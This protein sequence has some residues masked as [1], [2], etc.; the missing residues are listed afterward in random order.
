M[1][2]LKFDEVRRIT[3]A[4]L[5]SNYPGALI[6][7]FVDG[8]DPK[9]VWHVWQKHMLTIFEALNWQNEKLFYRSYTGGISL[10][11]SA[12][13]DALYTACDAAELGWEFCVAELEQKPVLNKQEKIQNLQTTLKQEI[14]PY[15]LKLIASAEQNNVS[16]LVDD[17]YFSL[18]TGV[19][20][21]VWEIDKLP[22]IKGI[23]WSKYHKIPSALITGTNGKSTSVRLASTIA[24]ADNYSAGVTSTDFIRVGDNIIDKGDY[25]GPGGARILLRHPETEIAF[26]EVARGGLLRRGVPINNNQAALI[27]NIA[28]D[29]LGQYGI[30][31]VPELAEAKFIVD[32]GLAHDGVLV[33]N[34]DDKELEKMSKK[35]AH[36]ICWFST[37]KNNHLI[38][39][40]IQ[41]GEPVVYCDSGNVYF[42]DANRSNN[43]N[44]AVKDIVMTFNGTATY[45]IYNA[46]GVIGLCKVLKLSDQAIL[47]GLASFGSNAQDNPGRGNRYEHHGAEV[48]IDF[49]HN[50]HSMNAVINMVKNIDANRKIVMFSQA[51]DRS[52]EEI[53]S[54]ADEILKLNPQLVIVAEIKNYLRGRAVG[55]IPNLIKKHLLK[56]QMSDNQIKTFNS[57]VEGAQYAIDNLQ[58]G[59][60]ALLF[61]LDQREGVHQ[62]LVG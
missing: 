7:A 54:L 10:S 32:K 25:S 44:V 41:Q 6:D 58:Q 43:F 16:Y 33:L 62:L 1:M 3:G 35:S 56:N 19:N 57:T 42:V 28:A 24:K 8:I 46:M 17:D 55:E 30:N 11:L 22:S 5:L 51:G 50:Q 4:N 39:K 12:P 18:G 37:N 40:N 14:N 31:T 52:D 2:T 26:L 15:L 29:H 45:N 48:I 36:K 60:L 53:L 9:N 59:D 21:E 13:I 34:A 47:K 61:T 20:S 27:T 49:A 23:D 38:Q